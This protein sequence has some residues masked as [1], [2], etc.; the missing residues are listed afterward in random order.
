MKKIVVS[1]FLLTLIS[2]TVIAQNFNSYG[3][4]FVKKS[5]TSASKLQSMDLKKTS[6]IEVEGEVKAVCQAAG[7][8]MTINLENG[9]T[10]RVTFKDYGFFVPKDI[11]GTNVV[12]KGKPEVTT[13]S[14]SDLKHYAADAGKSKAEIDAITEPE[15]ALT[16]V[17]DGVLVPSK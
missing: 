4:E 17:A 8:W 9:E 12:F 3:K 7:C 13:T 6:S 2:S 10:M 5:P 14:V 1:L 16:F 15:I 11:A